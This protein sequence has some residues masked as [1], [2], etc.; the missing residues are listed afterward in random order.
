MD[1]TM[2]SLK[3]NKTEITCNEFREPFPSHTEGYALKI[4]SRD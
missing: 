1:V 3:K 2:K 4:S